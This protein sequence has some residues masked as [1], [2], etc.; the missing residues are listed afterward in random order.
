MFRSTNTSGPSSSRH[1]AGTPPPR[2]PPEMTITST[3]APMLFDADGDF[4]GYAIPDC[5]PVSIDTKWVTKWGCEDELV[6]VVRWADG[7]VAEM[8]SFANPRWHEIFVAG[9]VER[10][11]ANLCKLDATLSELRSSSI[12]NT[13]EQS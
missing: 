9:I 1:S 4:S 3:T 10:S 8:V 12:S 5:D 7:T 11:R 2:A 6:Y 13:T